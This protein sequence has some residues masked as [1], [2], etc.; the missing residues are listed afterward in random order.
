MHSVNV[1]LD[2]LLL[3]N[4]SAVQTIILIEFTARDG[5]GPRSPIPRGEF[6]Y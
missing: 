3:A 6:L 1:H 5:N 2:H 4:T